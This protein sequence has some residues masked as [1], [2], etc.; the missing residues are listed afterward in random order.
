MPDQADGPRK[1]RAAGL[2]VISGARWFDPVTRP[3]LI[4][5]DCPITFNELVAALYT[6]A[7]ADDLG[8]AED[9][10]GVVA[11]TLL[12]EGLPALMEHAEQ[13]RRDELCGAIESPAFLALCRQRAAAL[14]WP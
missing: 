2:P 14:A 7:T 8:S 4:R 1:E 5:I 6:R 11:V 13:I 12:L 3:V 10:C 9:L